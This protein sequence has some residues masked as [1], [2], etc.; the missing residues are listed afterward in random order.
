MEPLQLKPIQVFFSYAREDEEYALGLSKHLKEWERRRYISTFLM[1][2]ISAGEDWQKT[3]D[4]RLSSA[5]IVLLFISADFIA[6]EEL[7]RAL[8]MYETGQAD[9]IPII[10]RPVHW[11]D[12]I[13]GRFKALPDNDKSIQE[14][15][16]RDAAYFNIA[17]GLRE[18][19]MARLRDR[20]ADKFPSP[21]YMPTLQSLSAERSVKFNPSQYQIQEHLVTGEKTDRRGNEAVK[22]YSYITELRIRTEKDRLKTLNRRDTNAYYQACRRWCE[23][24]EK[25]RKDEDWEEEGICWEILREFRPYIVQSRI[26][27]KIVKDNQ[28]HKHIYDEAKDCAEKG[29]KKATKEKLLELWQKAPFYGDPAKLARHAGLYIPLGGWRRTVWMSFFWIGLVSLLGFILAL[30]F[31]GANSPI[32]QYYNAVSGILFATTIAI[33]VVFFYLNSRWIYL[34]FAF[35]GTPSSTTSRSGVNSSRTNSP[36][37]KSKNRS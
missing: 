33:Y 34:K 31:A 9:I 4:T 26:R 14:W 2:N 8:D 35:T 21:P 24:A 28:E 16:D 20:Q 27:R 19:V 30:I 6:S 10:V 29:D 1:R 13:V 7:Q 11:Q 22:T 25:A 32:S 23:Q 36:Q 18:K 37:N 12:T 5:D 3:I 15:E 17:E